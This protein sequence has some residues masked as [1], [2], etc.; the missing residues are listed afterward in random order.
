MK[1]YRRLSRW[2][3]FDSLK[4]KMHLAIA[5]AALLPPVGLSIALF[6]EGTAIGT[7]QLLLV[8]AASVAGVGLA[9]W[10]VSSLL[11]PM[12][13][14]LEALGMYNQRRIVY[15]LPTDLRDDMGDLLRSVRSTLESVEER[16]CLL[17][18]MATEDSLTGLHNRRHA[19]EFVDLATGAADRAG[20]ALSLAMI[21]VDQFSDFNDRNGREAGDNA[22]RDVG[23]F[24]KLWLRRKGD[25]IARWEGDQFLAVLFSEQSGGVEF[26]DNLR[27]E[28]ARQMSRREDGALT[29]SIGIAAWRRGESAEQCRQRALETLQGAKRDG[30]N[31]IAA[32]QPVAARAGG[33][34]VIPLSA[35]AAG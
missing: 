18:Q 34:N 22:L 12:R 16:R 5:S 17:Q 26:L 11:A 4:D 33:A 1:N 28:F 3:P 2:L 15:P 6:L 30:G 8:L 31:R 29:L 24:L 19:D 21:D 14:T 32:Q 25:W 9:L 35:A 7:P 10:M 23:Q 27:R 13:L 20:A